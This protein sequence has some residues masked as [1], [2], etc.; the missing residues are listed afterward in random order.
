[1]IDGEVWQGPLDSDRLVIQ[2]GAG[3]HN[4]EIR[5]EGYRSYLTDIPIGNGQVRTLNV[6]LSSA[7][8]EQREATSSADLRSLYPA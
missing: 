5:K 1:M 6:A 4:V 2:L 8:A 7:K 3:T